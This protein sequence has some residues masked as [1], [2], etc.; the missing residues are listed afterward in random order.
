MSKREY[1]CTGLYPKAIL[2]LGNILRLLY[3]MARTEMSLGHQKINHYHGFSIKD[4]KVEVIF[5][6]IACKINDIAKRQLSTEEIY[7]LSLHCHTECSEYGN[8]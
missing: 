6:C 3:C 2:Y 7:E 8:L 4:V 5:I 1:I